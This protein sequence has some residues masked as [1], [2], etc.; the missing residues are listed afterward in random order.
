MAVAGREEVS[1]E[2]GGGGLLLNGGKEGVKALDGG[3]AHGKERWIWQR[4]VE[5]KRGSD[6]RSSMVAN[7]KSVET[8]RSK[9]CKRL[10]AKLL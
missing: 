7:L 1:V 6:L 10:Y 5:V 8:P 2:A 4:P 9:L 3:D